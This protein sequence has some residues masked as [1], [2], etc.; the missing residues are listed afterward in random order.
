MAIR[1]LPSALLIEAA[2]ALRT[3]RCA[4]DEPARAMLS[5]L[6]T[7]VRVPASRPLS[8][9]EYA[10][11]RSFHPVGQ[12]PRSWDDILDDL[13]VDTDL[14]AVVQGPDGPVRTVDLMNLAIA[15]LAVCLLAAEAQPPARVLTSAA[16]T[17]SAILAERHPGRTIEVRVPPATA[18]QI[19]FDHGPVHTRGT[20][21]SVIETD[22][23]TFVRLSAGLWT[24][25]QALGTA[26]VTASGSAADLSPA[27]PII[28]PIAL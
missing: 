8:L 27:L 1:K 3:Q 11:H 20:P 2:T 19:R 18:V 13:P 24:W 9:A 25:E 16:R 28:Q 21:P 6:A 7:S 17:L 14:P 5:H 4:P 23:A 26:A 22:P 15:E 12:Q 10:A